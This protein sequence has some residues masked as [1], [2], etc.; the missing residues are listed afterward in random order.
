MLVWGQTEAKAG[1][2]AQV[3]V[4]VGFGGGQREVIEVGLEVRGHGKFIEVQG[5][6]ERGGR[7]LVKSYHS[8]KY[9]VERR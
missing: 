9:E 1:A 5:E 3:K 2:E 8:S 4:G 7:R 6:V